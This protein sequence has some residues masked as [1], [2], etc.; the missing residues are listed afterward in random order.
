MTDDEQRE[1]RDEDVEGHAFKPVDNM[2][3]IDALEQVDATEEPPD[4]EGHTFDAPAA[5]RDA[6]R[7]A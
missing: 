7:D 5:P 2:D 3:Q 1:E 6:P 4:V